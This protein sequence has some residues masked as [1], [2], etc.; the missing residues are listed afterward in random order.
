MLLPDGAQLY[1]VRENV[2]DAVFHSI[3]V[4]Y[5]RVQVPQQD[6][7]AARP[8]GIADFSKLFKNSGVYYG[9]FSS[10]VSIDFKTVARPRPRLP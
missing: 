2:D 10:V 7:N 6:D 9:K 8:G 4:S 1:D 5:F 3:A